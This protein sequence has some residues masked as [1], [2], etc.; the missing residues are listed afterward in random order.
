MM[1]KNMIWFCLCLLF[2][3]F[4]TGCTDDDENKSVVPD[5]FYG[6]L[7]GNQGNYSESNGSVSFY[8]ERDKSLVNLYFYSR[9]GRYVGSMIEDI[10]AGENYTLLV[11]NNP[12]K[13]EILNS[14]TFVVV[15]APVTTGLSNPRRAV[16]NGAKAYVSCWGDADDP[17]ASWWT[18]SHGYVAEID[19][20]TRTI[21]RQFDGG[22]DVE[23]VLVSGNELFVANALGVKVFDLTSGENTANIDDQA[24]WNGSKF[25]LRGTGNLVWVTLAGGGVYS[26]DA[27]THQFGESIPVQVP[28]DWTGV[29][30]ISL[31]KN[32]IYYFTNEYAEDWSLLGSAIHEINL[33]TG[34]S[35]SAAEPFI[36]GT[37]FYGVGVNPYSGLIYT[38]EVANFAANGTLLVYDESGT[39][40]DSKE[41]GVGPCRFSFMPEE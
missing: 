35:T 3:G 25:L 5:P 2:A 40:I 26:F 16:I 38:G 36:S 39:L 13:V 9:N 6:V 22:S 41:V 31:N 14:G 28:I 15:G 8:K 20:A 19:L 32:K 37:Y 4:F 30:A 1:N 21:T 34:T 23:G 17:T 18:Y 11:C 33:L 27:S 7:I 24:P 29:A 10:C 12:G